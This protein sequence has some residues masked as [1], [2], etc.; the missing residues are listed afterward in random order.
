VPRKQR[1][2]LSQTGDGPIVHIL[3]RIGRRPGEIKGILATIGQASSHLGT[4]WFLGLCPT[5]V[6][7]RIKKES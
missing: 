1:C 5:N 4:A 6:H 3:L 7:L 2:L